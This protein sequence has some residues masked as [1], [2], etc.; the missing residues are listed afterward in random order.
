MHVEWTV[1][2]KPYLSRKPQC[3]FK[4]D[5]PSRIAFEKNKYR[6]PFTTAE[7]ESTV[8]LVDSSPPP[9]LLLTRFNFHLSGP[10]YLFSYQLMRRECPSLCVLMMVA[11]PIPLSTHNTGRSFTILIRWPHWEGVIFLL[12]VFSI[13]GGYKLCTFTI[14]IIYII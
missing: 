1:C 3:R 10:G 12:T 5:I 4:E 9:P 8:T 11:K 14:I 2:L 6:E 13:L 7:V